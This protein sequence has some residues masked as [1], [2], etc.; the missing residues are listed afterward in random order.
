MFG[1]RLLEQIFHLGPSALSSFLLGAVVESD[2]RSVERAGAL[3]GPIVITG[4]GAAPAAWQTIL[5]TTG[6]KS[7]R[8]S[9]EIVEQAFVQGLVRLFDLHRQA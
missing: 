6:R 8:L 9:A 7:Q 5:E 1:V 2:L 3:N 4:E